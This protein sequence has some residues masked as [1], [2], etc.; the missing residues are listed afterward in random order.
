MSYPDRT[1][2]WRRY[3]RLVRHPIARDVDDELQ[4]HFQSRI[5]DLIAAGASPDDARADA[6]QNFGNVH[7]VREDLVSIGY[8]VASRRR[9]TEQLRDALGDAR[10]A[11][12]SMRSTPGIA[13][14]I[15]MMLALGVGANAAMFTLLNSVF[16]RRP[17]GVVAPEGV[18]RVWA[19]KKLSTGSQYWSGFGYAQYDAIR[20]ALGDRASV[21]VYESPLKMKIG[22][23]ESAAE[24]RISRA[25][26]AF[27]DLL[28]AHAEVGRLYDSTEDRLADPPR[29][30]VVSHRYWM[31]AL[32][33]LHSSIGEAIVIAGSRYTVVGVARDPFVGVELDATDVWI[34]LAF[35]G[36]AR[37]DKTTWWKSPNIN[38]FQLLVR[39]AVG[40]ND[41]EIEQRITAALR[42][43]DFGWLNDS[44][45]VARLGSIV[46]ATGPGEKP[47]EVQIAIRLAG[48]ALV[49]LIIACANVANL[50]LGR[51]MRRRREI[52]VRLALGISRWRLVRLLLVES[53]VLAMLAATVAIAVAYGAGSML[54]RLLLPDVHWA[55]G[56][57]DWHVTTLAL[58][59]AIL[60]GVLAGLLP[61]LQSASLD[62]THALKTGGGAGGRRSH[63]RSALVVAQAALSVLL[64][65]GATLFVKSLSNVRQLD[66]G[67]DVQRVITA[68][69][70]YDDRSRVGDPTLPSRMADLASRVATIPGVTHVA[71]SGSPPMY[72]ISWLTFFTETDSSHRGFDPT[73][74]A[75]SRGYFEASGTPL[76]YGEDFPGTPTGAHS[77]IVNDAMAHQAWP[78]QSAIGQCMYFG[79]RGE[80]CYRVIGVAGNSR[81]SR[82]I[83]DIKPKYYLSF[84][85][86]PTI[87][88]AFRADYVT[89]SAN[90]AAAPVVIASIRAMIRQ[91]FPGGIPSIVRLSDYLEPQYRPWQLGATLFSMF[92]LLA[93]VVA[94]V[95]IYSTTSYGVQQRLHEFGVRIALGARF[96]DV[97]R[98]V[99][100][101][102]LR[103][104]TIGI[105]IGL[106]LALASGKFVASLLYGVKPTDPGSAVIV[107]FALLAAG[108]LAAIAPAWR[109]GR[110]DPAAALRSE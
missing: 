40:A 75:V 90:P 103:V 33:G 73:W 45:T 91:E 71:I 56:P 29:V 87:A 83:E 38:A 53:A 6:E 13:I 25:S 105:A 93:L 89:L 14:A 12:R 2:A 36:E 67:Y 101:E 61:A 82:L 59:A 66:I 16:L 30:A 10:Y 81:E 63:L 109:A 107:I 69:V 44:T 99:V 77:V 64:L 32:G 8:R 4:F 65:C 48:V 86:L 11:L 76:L 7:H 100:G 58:G 55:S 34:P 51:A 70:A 42:R 39:S 96:S 108:T 37:G 52:A 3:L 72:T 27:F 24:A 57:V 98:L 47:Q 97:T 46:R 18:R 102:G 104:V 31:N 20:S 80:P 54:R 26:V 28:G 49:V 19:L 68:T 95:G 21:A 110:V 88:K 17:A 15:V 85:D 62:F 35:A 84:N 43:P 94:V 106:A 5:D 92:G 79:N 60:F 9:H 78:G 22:L 50:L 41:V 74:S 1:P 23:G